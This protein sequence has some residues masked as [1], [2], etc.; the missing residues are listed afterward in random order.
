MSLYSTRII[1]KPVL[2]RVWPMVQRGG[3]GPLR[4]MLLICSFCDFPL[5]SEDDIL[6]FSS[7]IFNIP[8]IVDNDNHFWTISL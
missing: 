1:P 7:K 6:H 2:G 8:G 5:P 3:N 4:T